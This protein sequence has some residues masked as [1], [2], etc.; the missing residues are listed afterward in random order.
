M[1]QK[2][3][4]KCKESKSILEFRLNS[5]Q[6]DGL[7][8]DCNQCHVLAERHRYHKNPKEKEK[9]IARKDYSEE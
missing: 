6:C 7:S 5:G 9:T 3:C 2:V 4:Y 8:A 1:M